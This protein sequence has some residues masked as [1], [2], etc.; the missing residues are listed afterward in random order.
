M[1]IGNWIS[2]SFSAQSSSINSAG[3]AAVTQGTSSIN[4]DLFQHLQRNGKADGGYTGDGA[5]HDPRGI[6]HAGEV[7]WSQADIARAGGVGIVEAMRLG[8]RGYANGGVVGAPR[9]A[10][11]AMARGA[12]NV[13]IDGAKGDSSGVQ[14]EMGPSGDLDIRVSLRDLIRGE[15]RGGSFDNDFR[16]RYGLTYRGNRGG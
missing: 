9:A 7:V 4:N 10:A 15:I 12:V 5:K 14:A 1:G 8:L 3:N 11:A 6:V 13:Y 16:S 2:G